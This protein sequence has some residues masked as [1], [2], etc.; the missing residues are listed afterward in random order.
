L[1]TPHPL[2]AEQIRHRSVS[3]GT[4]TRKKF[5]FSKFSKFFSK[6]KISKFACSLVD[7]TRATDDE[8]VRHRSASADTRTRKIF[9]FSGSGVGS[10]YGSSAAFINY[11]TK[12]M[13]GGTPPPTAFPRADDPGR[14]HERPPPA[15]V[16]G[17]NEE[18]LQTKF[19][20][21]FQKIKTSKS[22]CS[23]PAMSPTGTPCPALVHLSDAIVNDG[24][25]APSPSSTPTDT[26]LQAMVWHNAS[27]PERNATDTPQHYSALQQVC[28]SNISSTVKASKFACSAPAMSP[29]GTPCPAQVHL[30]DTIVNDGEG[31]PSP[32]SRPTD[33]VLQA[34]VWHNIS[35]SER[36]VSPW[37][38][39]MISA[40]EATLLTFGH[41]HI[42]PVSVG[43]ID[44]SAAD[45]FPDVWRKIPSGLRSQVL[46]CH[47]LV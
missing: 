19:S 23:A 17:N 10:D 32:S 43:D 24:E 5:I 4:R 45:L 31:A 1:D 2:F 38:M 12:A 30:S 6:N 7:G 15:I 21:F 18:N 47:V 39:P 35:R 9:T 41:E 25:G 29:T 11:A 33:T 16:C 37:S 46:S 22:A 34:M 20:N 40:H 28:P 26:V 8:A 44:A 36:N 27:R 3:A 13:H 42:D 14:G